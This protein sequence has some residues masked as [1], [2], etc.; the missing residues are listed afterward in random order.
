MIKL[1][2]IVNLINDNDVRI[3]DELGTGVYLLQGNYSP[4]AI[5]VEYLNR[6]VTSIYSDECITD[7]VNIVVRRK[8]K[9]MKQTKKGSE[10]G[11]LSNTQLHFPM[12]RG[13][14]LENAVILQKEL[15]LIPGSEESYYLVEFIRDGRAE[16]FIEGL[17]ERKISLDDFFDLYDTWNLMK[18]E[19][20]E[21]VL[22][23]L[24]ED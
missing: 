6:E 1:K 8:E 13:F 5:S 22:R 21:A 16:K 24:A 18:S 12:T 4:D 17:A 19:E 23:R 9:Q 7:T 20:K 14:G 11:V 15:I 3:V 2:D 10:F